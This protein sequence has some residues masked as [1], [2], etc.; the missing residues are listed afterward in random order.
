M[1]LTPDTFSFLRL[2]HPQFKL[3]NMFIVGLVPVGLFQ[4][5]IV[6]VYGESTMLE[7]ILDTSYYNTAM[8]KFITHGATDPCPCVPVGTLVSNQTVS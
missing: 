6:P 5:P 1:W 7:P 8:H 2:L 4:L 3:G